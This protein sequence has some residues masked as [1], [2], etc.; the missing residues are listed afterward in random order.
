[1]ESRATLGVDLD[2][3]LAQF[4]DS[5][6][7]LLIKTSGRDL[8]PAHPYLPPCWNWCEPLGYTKDEESAAWE[9]VKQSKDFWRNLAAYPETENVITRLWA[10][11]KHGHDVYFITNRMGVKPKRQTEDWLADYTPT[12]YPVQ[13]VLV[14]A[15]KGMCAAALE[16]THYIDDKPSNCHDVVV[17]SPNTKTYM[18][19][20]SWNQGVE[21]S[22]V[23]RVKSVNAM[24][25]AIE[26]EM[27]VGT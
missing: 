14:S 13:T 19:D 2:G 18:M 11:Q 12:L 1:M 16:L 24:L 23:P 20:R 3:V 25:D 22:G 17:K 4:D 26:M 8:F 9:A 15:Q 5:F 21:I 6:T 10:L 27:Y 7:K